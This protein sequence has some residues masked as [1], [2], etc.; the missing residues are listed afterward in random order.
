MHVTQSPPMERNPIEHSPSSDSLV[1]LDITTEGSEERN[2][3]VQITAPTSGSFNQKSYGACDSINAA[4]TTNTDRDLEKSTR[5]QG[6]S[7]FPN[8]QDPPNRSNTNHDDDECHCDASDKSTL[9]YKLAKRIPGLG[10]IFALCASC[11]LGS[12]GMLVKL[13]QSVHGIQVAVFR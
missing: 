7:D 4:T 13:T 10:I 6:N 1:E 11:F 3:R 12:A 8:G 9:L 5:L 2:T